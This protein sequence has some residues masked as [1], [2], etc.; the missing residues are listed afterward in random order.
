MKVF[1][2]LMKIFEAFS[3][4]F[5]QWRKEQQFKRRVKLESDA[6]AYEKLTKATNA[7]NQSRQSHLSR[8]KTNNPARDK[9]PP[10]ISDKLHHDKYR[11]D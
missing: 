2:A 1:V 6:A 9:P 4:L 5:A 7:R 3:S 11:R 10:G 8:R